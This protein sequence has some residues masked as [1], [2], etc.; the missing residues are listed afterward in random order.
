MLKVLAAALAALALASCAEAFEG[1]AP[2]S[3]AASDA[4]GRQLAA[5]SPGKAALYVFRAD[6]PQ[7][8]VWTVL[9]GRTTI[10]QLGTMSWSRVEL[11]PGQY[12]LRCVGGREATPSLVLNLAAGETRYVD[13][14]TEWW[15]IAC[16]L[17]EVDAA[18]GRA[19]IAAGKRVLELN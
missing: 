16:T 14:G 2:M 17:N 15:K 10:S 4:A 6:K 18:A 11:L 9:A 19:G 1:R 13:L 3:D 12:D 8:I 7:P 5:P